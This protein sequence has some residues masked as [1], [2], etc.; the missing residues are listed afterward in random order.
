MNCETIMLILIIVLVLLYSNKL[1]SYEPFDVNSQNFLNNNAFEVADSLQ[2]G[3]PNNN[4]PNGMY[5]TPSAPIF[6]ASVDFGVNQNSGKDIFDVRGYNNTR[7]A[8]SFADVDNFTANANMAMN[9]E[10]SAKQ[11]YERGYLL[12]PKGDV[13]QYDVSNMPVSKYCCP[14]QYGTDFMGEDN[15]EKELYA[16]QNYVANN[17]SGMNYYSKGVGCPCMTAKDGEFYGSRGGNAV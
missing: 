14:S 15:A 16:S 11:Q 3:N 7:N 13:A 2:Y 8:E 12:D 4:N 5:Q 1:F 6:D 17:Y 10:A 9:A